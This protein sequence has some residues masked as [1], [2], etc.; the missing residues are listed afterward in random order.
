MSYLN[1]STVLFPLKNVNRDGSQSPV[2]DEIKSVF[3]DCK[4]YGAL[5]G[6]YYRISWVGKNYLE[7]KYSILITEHDKATYGVDSNATKRELNPLSYYWVNNN[8]TPD[9]NGVNTVTVVSQDG[10]IV[11]EITLDYSKI[12]STLLDM[13]ESSFIIDENCYVTGNE[14]NILDLSYVTGTSPIAKVYSNRFLFEFKKVYSNQLFAFWS[15][16]G[17]N[18]YIN[19]PY[20][21]NIEDNGV[22]V[23]THETDLIGP[24][25][26]EAVKNGD[27]GQMI[28]TGGQHSSTNGVTGDPTCITDSIQIFV[29][30]TKRSVTG[31]YYGKQIDIYVKNRIMSY[32]TVSLKRYTHI[33][34]VH[35]SIKNG[36]INVEVN[37]KPLEL[38]NLKTYYGLQIHNNNFGFIEFLGD[39]KGRQQL[40]EGAQ[41]ESSPKSECIVDTILLNDNL[42]QDVLELHMDTIGL[43]SKMFV[44]DNQSQVFSVSKSAKTYFR[45]VGYYGNEK[46]AL[47]YPNKI[48]KWSGYYHFKTRY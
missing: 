38:L 45:I 36:K 17:I 4:V 1:N 37:I 7:F 6:K 29:D 8:F 21:F 26:V 3:L 14:T 44:E 18:E 34:Y 2:T 11:V 9:E 25:V 28:F 48:Y 47:L 42:H 32:N 10:N 33:E 13:N 30:G 40:K 19:I 41:T 15:A 43:G 31:K 35:Y 22:R 46:G 27:N 20:E 24:Y 23:I 39:V 5:P 16:W 12:T